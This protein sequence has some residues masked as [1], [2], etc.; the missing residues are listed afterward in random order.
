MQ[1]FFG[2]K[3]KIHKSKIH[4]LKFS[5]AQLQKWDRGGFE[6]HQVSAGQNPHRHWKNSRKNQVKKVFKHNFFCVPISVSFI[7]NLLFVF[8]LRI[9]LF[10]VFSQIFLIFNFISFKCTSSLENLSILWCS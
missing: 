4:F 8:V 5:D 3:L 7:L 10:F 2:I 9:F 1:N 6:H